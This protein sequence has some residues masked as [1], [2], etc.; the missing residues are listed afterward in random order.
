MLS[1]IPSPQGRR[2]GIITTTGNRI[3]SR[4]QQDSTIRRDAG[5]KLSK[6]HYFKPKVTPDP[7][8]LS[9]HTGR[10]IWVKANSTETPIGKPDE[11]TNTTTLPNIFCQSCNTEEK[12]GLGGPNRPNNHTTEDFG[13]LEATKTACTQ[14]RAI[15][16]SRK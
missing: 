6:N 13:T 14:K 8:K 11:C 9:G 5:E 7:E 15:I 10:N 2:K 3:L 4:V 1:S 16:T 12:V